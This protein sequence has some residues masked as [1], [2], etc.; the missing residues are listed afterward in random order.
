MTLSFIHI[1]Q[2]HKNFFFF[3]YYCYIFKYIPICFGMIRNNT[4]LCHCNSFFFIVIRKFI[5]IIFSISGRFVII[6]TISMI[7]SIIGVIIF[8]FLLLI[9]IFFF[10]Y[11]FMFVIVI[12]F[13]II[14]MFFCKFIIILLSDFFTFFI[15]LIVSKF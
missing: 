5:F 12:F 9:R 14:G 4:M 8:V 7:L 15:I 1:D 6:A 11:L 3:Y 10:F 13:S 2:S